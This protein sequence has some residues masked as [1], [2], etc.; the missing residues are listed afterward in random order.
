MSPQHPNRPKART[1]LATA[2]LAALL[3][4]LITPVAA[5]SAAPAAEPASI[6]DFTEKVNP[7]VSTEDDFGQ[8]LPGAQA[9]NSIIKIN[10]MTTPGRAHSGYDYAETKIA[11]FTHTNL[12]GV[13]GSGGGGDLL[14]VPTYTQYT[15]R[16]STDSYAKAY[17]HDAE[18]ATPGYYSVD[19]TT[20]NGPIV[21]EATTDV[22]TGKDRFTFPKAGPASLV[23][24]LRNNFTSRN[25]ATLDVT[26]DPRHPSSV[27]IVW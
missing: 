9:P 8:D 20:S 26:V 13:G 24:D 11:G 14:V 27:Q 10:P 2:T 17:S 3:A 22:R 18:E 5:A 15:S 23:V 1:A 7:F 25:G 16:P 19:L 21:A 4:G 12:D 6:T